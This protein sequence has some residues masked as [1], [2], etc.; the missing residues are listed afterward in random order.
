[1]SNKSKKLN[2]DNSQIIM[3]DAEIITLTKNVAHKLNYD[4][5]AKS[6]EPNLYAAIEY[7]RPIPNYEG[8]Y[9][10][11]NLGRI[12]NSH[13]KI[14]KLQ[15]NNRGY[16]IY[17][18]NDCGKTTL[19]IHHLVMEVYGDHKPAPHYQI[20]HVD[21]N[22]INNC[23]ANLEWVTPSENTRRAYQNNLKQP[24]GAIKAF[25]VDIDNDNIIMTFS[26]ITDAAL[27]T[28]D[29]TYSIRTQKTLTAKGYRWRI[30][31]AS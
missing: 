27:T 28:G 12:K 26:T 7:W 19:Y 5:I 2:K 30:D 10:V 14:I 16:V 31:V 13:G 29:S 9:Y 23:I 6:T 21:G 18:F 25:Q 15:R 1:M 24:S 20:D 3:T 22:K 11:S 8:K 4:L 17:T